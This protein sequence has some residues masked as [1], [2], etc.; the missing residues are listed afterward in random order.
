M[1]GAA[2]RA[3]SR[4]RRSP[5]AAGG[6]L[7]RLLITSIPLVPRVVLASALLAALVA[8]AFAVLVLAVSALRTTTDQ[9][10][11]SK[12]VS[13]A[14]LTLARDVADLE[15]G[16]RGYVLTRIPRFLKPWNDARRS[17]PR[18]VENL[19]RLVAG[20]PVQRAR[21]LELSAMVQG[22]VTDYGAP[23]VAI[24][25]ISPAAARASVATAEGRR[26][27]E[28]IRSRLSRVLDHEDVLAKRRVASAKSQAHDAIE[29]GLGA[30]GV[31]AVLILLFGADLARGVAR[32]VRRAAEAA[33][34][35]A[36][37]DLSVR[38]PARGPREVRDL[39]MAFNAMA[40]SLDQRERD[41]EAQNEQLR[42]SER[43][44]SELI[45]IVSH[46]VRTPLASVLGYT[47][48]LLGREFDE[49]TRARYLS[50]IASESKR[51][52]SLIEEFLDAERVEQGR[53]DLRDEPFDLAAMLREQVEIF[54]GQSDRHDMRLDVDGGAFSVSG[55]RMRLSQVIANLLTN[56]IKY[57]PAGGAIDV[58]CTR[59]GSRLRVSVADRGIG[60]APEHQ[61][62]I[63]TKFFRGEA[64]ERGITGVGLGLAISREIVEAH[65][66]QMGFDTSPG[67]GTVFWF[68]LPG[69]PG[70]P[71]GT[72]ASP[73]TAR[74]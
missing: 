32:P 44:R 15:A 2:D 64:R 9:A 70:S 37:G 53:L 68:E 34:E 66:G 11:H 43:L 59:A 16:L 33:T 10:T 67:A 39:A 38:V 61:S 51:L 62:R 24:T 28:A 21:V 42:E 57:S 27:F 54:A 12:D 26:R 45:S 58:T 31:C 5:S 60:I 71:V 73:A 65:G 4:R 14:T 63:F 8:S 56:A 17:M 23:L 1:R 49:Q 72:P 3:A 35:A 7:R 22:Y 36:S 55:D 46:E 13:V 25:K 40:A 30:L 48:L 41:L 19:K 50:I 69:E 29:L 47:Q 52:A 6:Y 18:D 74:V 20:D